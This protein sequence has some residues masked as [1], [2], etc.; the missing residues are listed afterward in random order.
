LAALVVFAVLAYAMDRNVVSDVNNLI[1][2]IL[3]KRRAA[4]A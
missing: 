2:R 3:F 4:M 1:R